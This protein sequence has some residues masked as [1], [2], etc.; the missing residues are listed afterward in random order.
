MAYAPA[1]DVGTP[2][3]L[4]SQITAVNNADP[5]D[6]SYQT[7]TPAVPAGTKAIAGIVYFNADTVGYTVE[8]ADM[9]STVA[10]AI[11][12]SQGTTNRTITFSFKVLLVNG[13]F[14]YKASSAGVSGVYIVINEIYL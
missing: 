5:A 12:Y 14:R 8:L 4:S 2:K 3:W 11:Q 9:N 1:V 13:Q 10:R 7:V 6:T